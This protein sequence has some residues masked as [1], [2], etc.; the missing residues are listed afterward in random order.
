MNDRIPPKSTPHLIT[1]PTPEPQGN[2]MLSQICYFLVLRLNPKLTIPN[3]IPK[4]IN[5]P[6]PLHRHSPISPPNRRPIL[7]RP[8]YNQLEI[9]CNTFLPLFNPIRRIRRRPH[10]FHLALLQRP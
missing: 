7:H 2:T 3:P 4:G 8:P 5:N 6:P 10:K 1:P 9:L